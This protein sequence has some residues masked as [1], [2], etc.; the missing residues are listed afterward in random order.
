MPQSPHYNWDKIP[1]GDPDYPATH[2][3]L[4]DQ[5]DNELYRV[6]QG[7]S[8]SQTVVTTTT[9]LENAFNSLSAGETVLITDENAPYRTSQ[10]LD[11][12]KSG[13]TVIGRGA[14]P[15]VKPADGSNVGGIRVG[16]NSYVENILISGFSYHGNPSAQ[17]ANAG[18]FGVALGDVENAIVTNCRFERTWPFHEHNQNNSGIMVYAAANG[19]KLTQNYFEDIGDRAITSFGTNGQIVAN[20]SKNGFDRMIA[21]TGADKPWS[22]GEVGE[23]VIA[24]NLLENNMNG[25]VVGLGAVQHDV[26]I[27]GNMAYG[28]HRCL[29]TLQGNLGGANPRIFI[30]GNHGINDGQS[31]GSD[32]ANHFPGIR[33]NYDR[34]TVIG[35][36]L[37]GYAGFGIRVGNPDTSFGLK[38]DIVVQNNHV[39]NNL[40]Q[41][42]RVEKTAREAVVTNNVLAGNCIKTPALHELENNGQGSVITGN[43]VRNTNGSSPYRDIGQGW[44]V[45]KNNTS[46]VGGPGRI[47]D[48]S[49]LEG[50]T[51]VAAVDVRPMTPFRGTTSYHDPSVAGDSNPEGPAFYDGNSWISLVDGNPI[52]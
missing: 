8:S 28:D 21:L 20:H 38:D 3:N 50:N 12:D 2:S 32:Q 23:T 34:T 37:E 4:V 41:G 24:N 11:I 33:A 13:V 52:N 22:P 48:A 27:I 39:R 18:G 46:F 29:V 31:L 30:I 25:S 44:A 26:L 1:L 14:F 47:N 5:I 45:W 9:G 17:T 51:P 35:N 19:Y 15:L 43:V 16:A 36:Y 10:Y 42:I 6:E 40:E 7:G 49:T